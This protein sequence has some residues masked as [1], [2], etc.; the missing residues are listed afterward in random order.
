MDKNPHLNKVTKKA[1]SSSATLQYIIVYIAFIN[2]SF[3]IFPRG[4]FTDGAD[5]GSLSH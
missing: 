4:P 5:E 3:E 2:I 1:L